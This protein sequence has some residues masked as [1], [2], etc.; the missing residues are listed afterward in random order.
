M[1]HLIPSVVAIFFSSLAVSS[2]FELYSKGLD[3]VDEISKFKCVQEGRFSHPKT[4]GSYIECVRSKKGTF[5]RR[6]GNCHGSIFN[7]TLKHCVQDEEELH[8]KRSS[9]VAR[10]IKSDSMLNSLCNTIQY[11]FVCADCKTTVNCV[12][13]V[14]YIDAC[15]AGEMCAEKSEFNGAVCYPNQPESC[16]CTKE[17]T[18]R[19][20]HYNPKMFFYCNTVGDEPDLYQCPDGRIFDEGIG[21]CTNGL[22]LPECQT[23]G[24]FALQSDCSRYYTCIEHK[25]GWMQKPFTCNDSFMFNEF[26]SQ[27]EDPCTWNSGMFTCQKEGRFPDP[28]SCAH[29]YECVQQDQSFRQYRRQCPSGTEWDEEAR[30]GVGHCVKK[31]VSTCSPV[32]VNKCKIPDGWC[33]AVE[34][35]TEEVEVATTVSPEQVIEIKQLREEKQSLEN[36]K[37]LVNRHLSALSD[38]RS[39]LGREDRYDKL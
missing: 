1:G 11:G 33:A 22:G 21:Q 25:H 12:E 35:G 7:E 16:T 23:K 4:C 10:E 3:Q 29:Y 37:E 8:C 20:D 6:F 28:L 34:T 2:G 36:E 13:G 14:A 18:F 32:V 24:H 9:R 19:I 5:K 39:V 15:G 27:C 17:Q 31:V 30:G 38:T 26:T